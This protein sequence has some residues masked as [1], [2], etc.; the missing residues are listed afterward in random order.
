M[1]KEWTKHKEVILRIYKDQ[2]KTLEEVRRIMRE[3]YGFEAS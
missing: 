2:S 1:T 3:E